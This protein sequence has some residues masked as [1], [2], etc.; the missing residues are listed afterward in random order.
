MTQKTLLN[1]TE[2]LEDHDQTSSI[3]RKDGKDRRRS[4][5]DIDFEVPPLG[6]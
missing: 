6:S 5:T 3:W 2:Q 4:I 1:Q